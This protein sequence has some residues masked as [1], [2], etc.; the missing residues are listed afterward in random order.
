MNTFDDYEKTIMA[1]AVYP[2][3]GHNFVYPVL[4]LCGEAG[5]VAEKIKKT[6]RDH[7]GELNQERKATILKELGDVLWYLTATANECGWSLRDVAEENQ[8]KLLDRHGRGV[9][10]GEGDMR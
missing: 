10:H 5:E 1:L 2:N 7:G 3:I 4:G 6:L 8:R 9:L